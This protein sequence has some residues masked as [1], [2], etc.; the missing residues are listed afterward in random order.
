MASLFSAMNKK[1]IWRNRFSPY[2]RIGVLG[3]SDPKLVFV[4]VPDE[5]AGRYAIAPIRQAMRH[6]LQTVNKTLMSRHTGGGPRGCCRVWHHEMSSMGNLRGRIR[7]DGEVMHFGDSD[8]S[9]SAVGRKRCFLQHVLE[10]ATPRFNKIHGERR[11]F[12]GED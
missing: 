1:T 8:F 2:Q 11:R 6:S 5:G 7:R 10:N 3:Q 12:R 4:S 9:A